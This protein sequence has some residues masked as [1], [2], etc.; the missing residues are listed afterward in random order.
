[1]TWFGLTDD[2]LRSRGRFTQGAPVAGW[3]GW[4]VAFVVVFGGLYGAVMASFTGLAP[5][6]V[7]QLFYVAAKVPLLLLVSFALCLPSFFV[8]NTLA[9]LRADFP[10]ALRAVVATQAGV[11]VVLASLAPVTI[12]AYLSLTDYQVAKGFNGVVF[13]A[14]SLGGQGLLRRYYQPL[15]RR[16]PRHRTMLGF[17][18]VLYVFV[19]IQ[20]AWVLRPFIG[21]PALPVTFFRE[22][23]WGNA[24]VEV[25]E[26]IRRS[27]AP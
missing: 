17:W 9:G 5:G 12:L 16:S 1:M 20:M 27:L 18:F 2:F 3:L 7:A 25:L 6:R 4:L 24:Y 22:E 13:A 11:A 8:L 21:N 10:E 23:Q 19:A 15:I 14:A 26:T